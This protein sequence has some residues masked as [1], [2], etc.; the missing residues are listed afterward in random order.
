MSKDADV[1][2]AVSLAKQANRL[3]R[4][5]SEVEQREDTAAHQIVE[6][7]AAA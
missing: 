6:S 5:A 7:Q 2:K 1:R 4:L 3:A